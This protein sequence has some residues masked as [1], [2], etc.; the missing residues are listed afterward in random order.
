MT[1]SEYIHV[2]HRII[3]PIAYSYNPEIVLVSAGFD[4]GIDDPLGFYKL[5]PEVYGHFIQMLKPLAKG[6]M[7]LALEGGYNCNTLAYSI[8]SCVKTL[9][10]DPVPQLNEFQ[11]IIPKAIESIDTVFETHKPYWDVLNV[12]KRLPGEEEIEEEEET[13]DKRE[14]C[15]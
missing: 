10:G 9:L 3:L 5:T 7:I 15:N 6:R 14:S 13:E 1:D 12:D 8:V 11:A 2:F 4:A